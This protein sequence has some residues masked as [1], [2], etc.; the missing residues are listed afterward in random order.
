M[1]TAHLNILRSA[2]NAQGKKLQ[3]VLQAPE[4]FRSTF[5]AASFAAGYIGFYVCNGAVIAQAFGDA[6]ADRAA[7]KLLQQLFP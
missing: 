3:V 5:E 6:N 2:R 4:S 1:T 7:I